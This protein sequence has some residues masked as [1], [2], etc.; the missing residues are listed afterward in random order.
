MSDA[1]IAPAHRSVNRTP[2]RLRARFVLT[3]R[4]ILED[5]VVT[6]AD[7]RI[8]GVAG[9]IAGPVDEDLG[10][11]ALVPGL[12]NAHSHAFQRALRGRTE[13]LRADRP[14]ED[15]WSWRD[16][17]YRTA[18]TLEPEDVEV[19]SSM[20]FLEMVLGG[21]TAVGEF[22]Y[23]HHAPDGRP[24]ADPD[25]LAHRVVRAARG[26]G[27]RIALL[28]VLYHRAG[29]GRP[30]EP[31]QRRFVD[32]DVETGLRR[33]EA[34]AAAWAHDPAVSVGLAPHSVR[35]VP[36]AWLEAVAGATTGV[37]HLH[38][39]EQR[40]EIAQ[41]RAEHG[42]D[43]IALLDACGLLRPETTLVHATHL[44]PEGI[45]RIVEARPT[46]CVCP[47]TERN[48]GDGFL[49]AGRLVAGGVPLAVGSDSQADID[50][51]SE[52]RLIEYQERLRAERR[53]VLAAH[54]SVW[55]PGPAPDGRLETADVLGPMGTV[56]GARALGVAAGVI[57][58]GAPADLVA[59]DLNHPRLAGASRASLAAD[60]V[61]SAGP[62]CV[63]AVWVGGE[64]VVTGGRHE[65]APE[66]VGAFKALMRRLNG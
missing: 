19:V 13:H 8:L 5:A 60:L 38:A 66:I 16:L 44:T 58:V 61:F 9:N 12:I 35:A 15:F 50:L 45:A 33:A 41:C 25:E 29:P 55:A 26:V 6:V 31:A 43:P 47:T 20:A 36:R 28:R 32:A 46:I 23:L 59:L 4:G 63:R 51:W 14:D 30:A 39:C 64:R 24:Y 2:L 56:H 17:M 34:I 37:V 65:R 42:V 62:A 11:A 53:N 22:H 40:A 52:V 49:P 57:S 54:R 27:L 48:L 18:L 3:D 21:V 10:E 1:I 7:G